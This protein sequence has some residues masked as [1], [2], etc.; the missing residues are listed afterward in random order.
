MKKEGKWQ[1]ILRLMKQNKSPA[2]AGKFALAGKLAAG[3][4]SIAI[5]SVGGQAVW[6]GFKDGNVFR[7]ELFANSQALHGNQ[8]SFPDQDEFKGQ[9]Q[10]SDSGENEQLQKDNRAED[11]IGKGN[12]DRASFEMDAE[13]PNVYSE[14]LQN[15]VIAPAEENHAAIMPPNSLSGDSVLLA[16]ENSTDHETIHTGGQGLVSGGTQAGSGAGEIPG[17]GNFS[18][19]S[20]D[21]S[22]GNGGSGNTGGSGTINP[23]QPSEPNQPG[24]VTPSKPEI[25]TEPPKPGQSVYDP[26]YPDGSQKPDLPQGPSFDGINPLYPNFPEKGLSEKYTVELFVT[27]ILSASENSQNYLYE[28][29]VLTDW[30]LL[31][32][33]LFFMRVYEDGN[34][35]PVRQYRIVKYDDC[36]RVGEFPRYAERGLTVTFYYRPNAE[37]EWQE[38]QVT[39]NNIKFAKYVVMNA[40]D[41]TGQAEELMSGYL[42]EGDSAS[43]SEATLKLFQKNP[44]WT[45]SDEGSDSLVVSKLFPGWSLKPDGELLRGNIFTPEQGGRYIL[46]P[47]KRIPVP[48]GCTVELHHGK[49]QDQKEY[50]R[51]VLT[52]FQTDEKQVVIP[53]GIQDVQCAFS[54][55]IESLSIPESVQNFFT[56]PRVLKAYKVSEYNQ[57]FHTE[58]DVLYDDSRQE[59][60]GIPLEK[61][62]LDVPEEIGRI[63]IPY[64]NQLKKIVLHSMAPPE[65]DVTMLNEASICIPSGSYVNYIKAWGNKLPENVIFE[66]K[67][68]EDTDYTITEDGLFSRDG[69][70]LRQANTSCYGLYV[71]PDYVTEIAA[72]AFE[73]AE[74]VD[75]VLIPETVEKL[76]TESLS[77]S[78]IER[79]YF[80]GRNEKIPDICKG[81]FDV[82]ENLEEN[83]EI[84]EEADDTDIME[85]ESGGLRIWVPEN[86][87]E[88][89]IAKWMDVL[90]EDTLNTLVLEGFSYR[91]KE[92]VT[93]IEA[94]GDGATLL[95]ANS[96]ISSFDEMNNRIR[97]EKE[98]TRI[99]ARAFDFSFDIKILEIPTSVTEVGE[100]AF[101]HCRGLEVIIFHTTDSLYIGDYAFE[102]LQMLK[103]IAFETEEIVLTTGDT[104]VGRTCY[105]PK[106][107]LMFYGEGRKPLLQY[108]GD[109]Y[110]AVAGETGYFV[111]G[112]YQ[113]NEESQSGEE[114]LQNLNFS[115]NKGSVMAALELDEIEVENED[116]EIKDGDVEDDPD[117]ED[118]PVEALTPPYSILLVATSNVSGEIEN[119]ELSQSY[120]IVE[121][122]SDALNGCNAGELNISED[123]TGTIRYIGKYAFAYSSLS[124]SLIFSN[125]MQSIGADAFLGCD[126]LEKISFEGKNAPILATHKPGSPYTFGFE[127]RES[128]LELSV[129]YRENY[130][131][132]WKY[133]LIGYAPDT[134]EDKILEDCM[135]EKIWS[136]PGDPFSDAFML[137]IDDLAKYRMEWKLYQG[138]T[139]VCNLLGFPAPEEP[140]S[141]EPNMEDYISESDSEWNQF[142][143]STPS[144][145][146]YADE[147]LDEDEIWDDETNEKSDSMKNDHMSESDKE[148]GKEDADEGSNSLE[149]NSGEDTAES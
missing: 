52:Q 19:G 139:M 23:E 138:D 46:Y 128:Q 13:D 66:T 41:S 127:E 49:D 27:D 126:G 2:L 100:E 86:Q 60:V 16:D 109:V 103:M 107:C 54:E 69:S 35:T 145:A 88:A 129:T 89:Y 124:G 108:G 85:E 143:I 77:A 33:A 25:P 105:V 95:H 28:G 115:K 140:S 14:E 68:G 104:V 36:F 6:N 26:D 81:T 132:I 147:I 45:K 133:Y 112:L 111:Y 57:V 59:I 114:N 94:S 137:Y 80:Y 106:N 53:E 21:F 51:Q 3:A 148:N 91:E 61:E 7:P 71:V 101:T 32:S 78:G 30:K 122:V 58:D 79:I 118:K 84:Q 141:M 146:V 97:E 121:I 22:G 120:P 131:D 76:D 73:Q 130:R 62:E 83:P 72:K 17:T 4:A 29:A 39:F 43:L 40:E 34:P 113:Q 134:M 1:E 92:G 144:D 8:I 82:S 142:G 70:V 11:E 42:D 55:N 75:S 31:Y 20:S 98:W 67:E 64:N 110:V 12:D 93:W 24:E 102:N 65:M 38:E 99:G 119:P 135:W 87:R 116:E 15:V 117:H 149:I 96:D 125:A 47:L 37:C 50:F 48:D 10:N 136:W 90:D 63:A 9:N 74:H 123:V 18:G 44:E 56:I 5:L